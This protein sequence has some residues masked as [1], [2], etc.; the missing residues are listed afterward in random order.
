MQTLSASAPTARLLPLGPGLAALL[1]F[2][3]TVL[4]AD[5]GDLQLQVRRLGRP[6]LWCQLQTTAFTL[7]VAPE[8]L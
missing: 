7:P 6:M 2:R 5:A 3:A 8:P 1:S 4:C